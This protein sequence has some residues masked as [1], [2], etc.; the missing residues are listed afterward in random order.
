MDNLSL[1]INKE[2]KNSEVYKKYLALKEKIDNDLYLNKLK[3]EIEELKS[4]VCKTKEENL[5]NRYYETENL[6]K[7]NFIVKEYLATKDELEV[8][9]LDIADILSLN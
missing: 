6:Y 4:N 2:I 1:K 5:V 7:N 8:L 9:L 3:K